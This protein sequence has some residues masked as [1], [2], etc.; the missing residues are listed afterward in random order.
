MNCLDGNYERPRGQGVL[1]RHM[2]TGKPARIA[3]RAVGVDEA[4]HTCQQAPLTH[5]PVGG[6]TTTVPFSTGRVSPGMKEV[7]TTPSLSSRR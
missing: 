1:Q 4:V 7:R 2:K 6:V 3:G 5:A